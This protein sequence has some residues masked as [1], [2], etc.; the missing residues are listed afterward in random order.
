MDEW[1]WMYDLNTNL[2][3]DTK[4]DTD[5]TKD[6]EY[7]IV[8]FK[9]IDFNEY[10]PIDL[11]NALN[12]WY[13]KIFIDIRTAKQ[14]SINSIRKFINIPMDMNETLAVAALGNVFTDNLKQRSLDIY[15]CCDNDTINKKLDIIWYKYLHQLL[16]KQFCKTNENKKG[17]ILNSFNISSFGFETIEKRYNYLTINSDPK[18]RKIAQLQFPNIIIEGKLL[19]GDH[20]HAENRDVIVHF[21]ITHIIN[22]TNVVDNQFEN[23][24]KLNYLKYLKCELLD[25]PEANI[26]EFFSKCIGFIEN[27]LNENNGNNKHVVLVHCFAGI[28]R[29]AAIVMAYLM[30]VKKMKYLEAFMFTQQKREIIC[31]NPGFQKQLKQWENNNYKTKNNLDGM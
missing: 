27:A 12:F 8:D 5:E 6:D 15:C 13:N 24:E 9:T 18:Y 30:K 14:Y 16:V 2:N 21:G 20:E 29:S 4:E 23:D 28:S 31:P 1:S 3:A 17:F 26:D 7:D 10:D 22:V 19:L 25:I 11:H